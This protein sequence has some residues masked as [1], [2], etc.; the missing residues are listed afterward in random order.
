MNFH[1]ND[2]L[3]GSLIESAMDRLR[4]CGEMSEREINRV[5]MELVDTKEERNALR[6]RLM[7]RGFVEKVLRVTPKG[8]AAKPIR[9]KK[10]QIGPPKPRRSAPHLD[11]W[12][13]GR[14]NLYLEDSTT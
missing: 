12:A 10:K 5:L 8:H 14:A 11:V 13:Q 6:N 4:G 9:T 1:G 7:L 3:E 2:Y